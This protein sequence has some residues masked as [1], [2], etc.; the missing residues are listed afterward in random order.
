M[1]IEVLVS[2]MHQKDMHLVEAMRLRTDTIVINQTDVFNY[3]EV[4]ADWGRV[5][6]FSFVERGVGLSRN[7]ALMRSDADICV[8]ADDDMVFHDGYEETVRNAFERYP[9]ADVI[10]FNLNEGSSM[11]GRE[12]QIASKV[13]LLNYM[14]Y[15]A[16]RVAFRRKAVTYKGISFNLNFG[17]GTQHQCGEDTLFLRDC[18][19]KGLRMIA[20]PESLAVLEDNRPSTWFKGYTD[21]YLFDKG[22]VLKLAHPLLA[23]LFGLYLTLRHPEY[24][25]GRSRLAVFQWM[26]K[27]MRY[28]AK[29][30]YCDRQNE[31]LGK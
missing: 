31:E 9:E 15:G 30:G 12:N 24:A 28:V 22:I 4:K 8:L 16:A 6:F 17:G 18:L 11:N 10:I 13:G 3:E 21:K 23:E 25:Q 26:W 2:T 1:R 29:E 27:G 7:S 14:N 20:V 19:K 5:R